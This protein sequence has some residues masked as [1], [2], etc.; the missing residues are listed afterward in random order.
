MI[1]YIFIGVLKRGKSIIL[2]EKGSFRVFLGWRFFL[3]VQGAGNK[4]QGVGGYL[5][6]GSV[7]V[8]NGRVGWGSGELWSLRRRHA[9]SLPDGSVE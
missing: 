4:E 9:A 2:L 6:L 7:G 8:E 1:L 3:R 5:L